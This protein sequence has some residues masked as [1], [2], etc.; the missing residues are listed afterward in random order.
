MGCFFRSMGTLQG[1]HP[2]DFVPYSGEKRPIAHL[3]HA[4]PKL[5]ASYPDVSHFR[6]KRSRE[7]SL[8]KQPTPEPFTVRLRGKIAPV[9]AW[10]HE[11]AAHSSEA[12]CPLRRDAIHRAS[13]WRTS[14]AD[15]DS[16]HSARH[17]AAK[18]SNYSI[19][20]GK[21][22]APADRAPLSTSAPRGSNAREARRMAFA[23]HGV[24][25]MFS[26]G[27]WPPWG[28]HIYASTFRGRAA[29][30]RGYRIVRPPWGR[31]PR[32]MPPTP[33]PYIYTRAKNAPRQPRAQ[34]NCQLSIVN[35]QL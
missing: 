25:V 18:R 35:C 14:H 29:L 5:T 32:C 9:Q 10:P 3:A 22:S 27:G 33:T 12:G 21:R 17:A 26:R 13:R 4:P 24:C 6:A 19:T 11:G 34:E 7:T 28:Q 31:W 1:K 30:T 15:G 20:A 23:R 8:S 16:Q 2:T